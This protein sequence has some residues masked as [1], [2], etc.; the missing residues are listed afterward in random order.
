[1]EREKKKPNLNE[2]IDTEYSSNFHVV[3]QFMEPNSLFV[4]DTASCIKL[5]IL[6][7]ILKMYREK[8]LLNITNSISFKVRYIDITGRK[9]YQAYTLVYD[10]EIRNGKISN[11]YPLTQN[12]TVY[13]P[14]E[15]KD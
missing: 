1:M 11:K 3:Y 7:S 13:P 4:N 15:I 2:Y 5:S 9:Y 8:D 14:K 12:Y 6:T 10:V